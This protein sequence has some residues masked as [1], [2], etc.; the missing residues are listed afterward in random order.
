MLGRDHDRRHADCRDAVARLCDWLVA[1]E[2]VPAASGLRGR[3]WWATGSTDGVDA[4]AERGMGVLSGR[5]GGQ[6]GVDVVADLAR[7]RARA[8]GEPRVALS[9]IVRHGETA[10][11]VLGR[12]R[13]DPALAW[14]DELVVQ[15]QPERGV[16]DQRQVMR[17]LAED[18]QPALARDRA[19]APTL[20]PAG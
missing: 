15:T 5:P 20:E 6:P 12:W 13:A 2:L 9:R 17:M 1:P 4:A 10:A 8:T 7:Y 16:A 18:V 11:D 19:P 14:G 3:L